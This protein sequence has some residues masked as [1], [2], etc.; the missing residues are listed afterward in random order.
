MMLENKF[1]V[2]LQYMNE[3]ASTEVLRRL[4]LA[5][6]VLFVAI[7]L[8]P[9]STRITRTS[10]LVLLFAIWAGLFLLLRQRRILHRLLL[11]ASLMIAAFLVLPARN[12]MSVEQLRREYIASLRR[13]E[14]VAYYWGGEGG[15]GIDCSGLIRRGLMD[16]MLRR[17]LVTFD[18]GLVRRA[19]SLWWNDTSARALGEQHKGLT[20]RILVTPSI[21]ALDHA[22]VVPGDL[23]VT[24]DGLHIMAYLG[25]K[26]WIE[27]D[28]GIGRVIRVTA[29]SQ[30]NSWFQTP[31]RIVRWTILQA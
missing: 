17:G 11:A 13:Y 6:L 9:L 20:V 4:W 24:M 22:T 18:G 29:P 21:N 15:K 23:T 30:G 8:F 25:D 31:M 26:I 1:H 5:A 16:A 28:P 10:E 14:G 2:S 27:A 7:V 3:S 12:V 19:L